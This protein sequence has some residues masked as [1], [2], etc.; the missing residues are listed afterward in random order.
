MAAPSFTT[1][2]VLFCCTCLYWLTPGHLGL[3]N[4]PFAML[5]ALSIVA[6]AFCAWLCFSLPWRNTPPTY[7]AFLLMLPILPAQMEISQVARQGLSACYSSNETYSE[8]A[9]RSLNASKSLCE[10]IDR[11][12]AFAPY[13]FSLFTAN[14]PLYFANDYRERPWSEQLP[15]VDDYRFSA[16]WAG[17]INVPGP[18]KRPLRVTSAGGTA[19]WQLDGVD[20]QPLENVSP[21][22]HRINLNFA[23]NLPEAPALSLEWDLGAG[24]K[25]VPPTAMSPFNGTM[26]HRPWRWIGLCSWLIALGILIL[27]A[28][29][30]APRPS[31]VLWV[32]GFY[33]LFA[34][35]LQLILSE[36][37]RFGYQIMVPGN[38]YLMYETFARDILNG[39][40]G[41]RAESPFVYF[42]FGY[43]YLLALLHVLAGEAPADVAIVQMGVMAALMV[44]CCAW[45]QRLFGWLSALA[46]ATAMIFC[47]QLLL[48]A[49]PLLD[50]TWGIVLSALLLFMLLDQARCPTLSKAIGMGLLLGLATLIRPNFIPFIAIACIWMLWTGAQLRPL[51][52]WGLP[53]LTCIL[54]VA[55]LSLLGWRNLWIAGEFRWLPENGPINLWFGNHPPQYD[56]PSF[57]LPTYIPPAPEI[58]KEVLRYVLSDPMAFIARS[59]QKL[60]FILGIDTRV[61]TEINLR[62]LVP[63]LLAAASAAP[64]WRGNYPAQRREVLLIVLWIAALSAPLT[65]IFPWGYGWRLSSPTFLP[66]YLLDGL[67]V[68]WL[69]SRLGGSIR[70]LA[71]PATPEPARK[72]ADESASA[73]GA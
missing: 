44:A 47:Q 48:L 73:P 59:W 37:Q 20:A 21:G 58:A 57:F 6:I 40:L 25:A 8:P 36:G 35:G 56:G 72:N 31:G 14:F 53:L 32:G 4:M 64:L 52:R 43:R 69:C 24:F 63:W 70:R 50:T 10:H 5:N 33:G 13:G 3:G 68:A 9:Q 60:L 45:T 30:A 27:G 34:L 23:R 28:R 54:A 42:N 29:P 65:L 51:Q 7:A 66:L 49:E 41:S 55:L 39:D 15:S 62:I 67:S 26:D 61:E 1:R 11:R 22:R 46:M 18:T 19:H 16:H 71:A 17:Y 38:D 12:I 2:A